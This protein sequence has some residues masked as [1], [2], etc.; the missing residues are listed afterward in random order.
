MSILL[1]THSLLWLLNTPGGRVFGD[2][3]KQSLQAADTVLVSSINL[4]EINI[5]A[6]LGKLQPP[7]DLLPDIDKA[8]L[9]MIDFTSRHAAAILNFPELARH[10]PFDRMLLA[11]ARVEGLSLL[12]S[13]SFLLKQGLDFI[14]DARR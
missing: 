13:D 10:D 7:V 2:Q 9:E 14:L 3:A 8:G 12:T 5:K 4:L 6:M 11:Q 1:D